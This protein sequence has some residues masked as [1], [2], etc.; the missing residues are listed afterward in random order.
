MVTDKLAP[1]REAIDA[2]RAREKRS[3]KP[4]EP[5]FGADIR[6]RSGSWRCVTS[7][8]MRQGD[9]EPVGYWTIRAEGSSNEGRETYILF[10]D[11]AEARGWRIN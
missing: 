2:W 6:T 5:I 7:Y 4:G 10:A 3:A 8:A 9:D 11:I 1:T